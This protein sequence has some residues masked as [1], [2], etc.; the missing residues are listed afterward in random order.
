MGGRTD[1]LS[2]L[3]LDRQTDRR[4]NGQT[5][6]R[7]ARDRHME[8][9]PLKPITTMNTAQHAT[10]VMSSPTRC[11]SRRLQPFPAELFHKPRY[12]AGRSTGTR[13][14]GSLEVA[15]PDTHR[16]ETW[17]DTCT[18]WSVRGSVGVSSACLCGWTPPDTGRR[19]TACRRCAPTSASWGSG[20]SWTSYRTSRNGTPLVDRHRTTDA[21][22]PYSTHHTFGRLVTRLAPVLPWWTDTEPL[23]RRTPT[24]HTTRLDVLSH[25]SHRNSP[26]GQTQ[27]HWH[28]IAHKSTTRVHADITAAVTS[29]PASL[30]KGQG[31]KEI[32]HNLARGR[33]KFGHN[34]V[35]KRNKIWVQFCDQSRTTWAQIWAL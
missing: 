5:D 26:G 16:C 7:M 2:N 3:H 34:L 18:S 4:T 21:A 25:A 29:V 24:A 20:P 14:A 22:S 31:A 30:G 1:G 17:T 33:P 28:S 6:R 11:K 9:T 27:N 23:T 13:N 35:R 15:T 12:N 32:G 8:N 10:G 19:Q